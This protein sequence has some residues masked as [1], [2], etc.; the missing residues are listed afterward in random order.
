MTT[1]I[2]IGGGIAGCSTAYALAQRGIAV[3]LIERHAGIAQEASGNLLAMLYP[4]LS[5]KPSLQ[6]MITLL[7]FYFTTDLLQKLENKAS[8]FNACGQIQLAFNAIEKAKQSELLHDEYVHK[9]SY[10]FQFVDCDEASEIAGI[11]LKMGGIFL[12]QAGWVKPRV[13]CA[14]LSNHA[15]IKVQT[16]SNVMAISP[17][18]NGW[19]VRLKNGTLEAE[20][21]V[22]CNANDVKQ[23]GFCASAQITPVRG[24]I[25]FF[26]LNAASENL[27]T[28]ICSDH[29]LSPSVAGLHSIGTTYSINH[30]PN[31]FNTKISAADTQSNLHALRK[32]SPEIL[33]EI[34]AKTVTSRVAY[35]SQTLDYR[36][37]AGQLLDEE[38]LRAK[39]KRH[40]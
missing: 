38:K 20:N 35:R 15:L 10:F 13:L 25:D 6:S 37:L 36:P 8:F 39:L 12:P 30:A 5:A 1:A 16:A 40:D 22:I 17:S 14:A 11:A 24:Q 29:Y 31:D 2:V 4:K 21:I 18:K 33:C 9:N 27:K 34:D 28:I 7:G 32:I 26:A 19:Q 23:F 3:T